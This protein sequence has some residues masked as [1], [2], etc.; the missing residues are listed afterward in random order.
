MSGIVGWLDKTLYPGFSRNWDD[1]LFRSCILAQLKPEMSI[2]DVG[3]GAGIVSQMNFRG[4]VTRICGVDLDPRVV[5][6]PN[7]DEGRVADA[8]GI[9]FESASFDLAF[10]DNVME[11]LDD[12]AQVLCEIN[13]V[14]KPGGILLF[15]TPNK[16]HYAPIIAR[17]TPHWFHQFVNKLRGRAEVDTFPT[18]Y[19]CNTKRDASRLAAQTGFEV[20]TIDRI[21]GRPEYLRMSGITYLAGALYERIVN[22]TAVL[23]PIRVLLIV[24]LRKPYEPS[25]STPNGMERP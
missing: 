6:N 4:L 23:A 18:L 1:L 3:A 15:K 11:H 25:V 13:R 9:P 5:S 14:L 24:K 12:P 21:E 2:L 22:A 8:G 19:K 16:N 10:A 17:L 20:T 7:L